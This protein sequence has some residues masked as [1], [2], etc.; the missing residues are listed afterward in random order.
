M[1]Q[2]IVSFYFQRQQRSYMVN[3][4]NLENPSACI[5]IDSDDEDPLS[6]DDDD[7]HCDAPQ[8]QPRKTR[9]RARK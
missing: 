3:K 2:Q 5:V 7:C 1:A 8:P 6:S 4:H 9:K